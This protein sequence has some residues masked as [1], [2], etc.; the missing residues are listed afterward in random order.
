MGVPELAGFA[1]ELAAALADVGR[2]T[3]GLAT[4]FR[5][6][7]WPNAVPTRAFGHNGDRLILAR[8]GAVRAGRDRKGGDEPALRGKLA[9]CRFFYRHDLPRWLP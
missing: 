1:N 4:A 6:R 7:R 9:A 8:R 5:R 2:A 3:M